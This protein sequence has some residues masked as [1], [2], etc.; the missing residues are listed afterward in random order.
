MA[1]EPRTENRQP[2]T[3]EPGT[4]E[5]RKRDAAAERRGHVRLVVGLIAGALITLFA[6][7]NVNGVRVHWLFAT[8]RTP[9]IVVIAVA[10]LFGIIVD[11]LLVVRGRRKRRD[12]RRDRA[13]QSG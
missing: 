1:R 4:A 3:L 5:L 7:L 13:R 6:V 9:L 10:F 2:A 12:S 11:R 8:G